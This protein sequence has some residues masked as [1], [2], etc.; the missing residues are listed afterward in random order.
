M[1]TVEFF[2]T[3]NVSQSTNIRMLY[4]LPGL[5]NFRASL[6]EI[7]KAHDSL[8]IIGI[9]VFEMCCPVADGLI[10]KRSRFVFDVHLLIVKRYQ[11]HIF[12]HLNR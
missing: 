9:V 12:F 7:S 4:F 3:K 1:F 8:E 5:D 10:T 6:V 11:I 2:R